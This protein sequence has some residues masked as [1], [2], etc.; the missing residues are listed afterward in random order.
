MHPP[1]LNRS[2]RSSR[3]AGEPSVP[4]SLKVTRWITNFWPAPL[5]IDR[6]E[7]LRVIVGAMF[8]ILLTAIVSRWW[9]GSATADPWML[10]S[11]GASAVLVFCMPSSPLAQPWPLLGGS[12]LSAVVG[13]LCSYAISDP[14]L[15]GA[16]AVGAAIALMVPLRCLHPPGGGVALYVVLTASDGVHLAVFPI[17]INVSILLITGVVYNGLTG[18]SYPHPQRVARSVATS[19]ASGA[20]TTSDIDAALAHYNE[21]LDVSRADLEG[22]L[23]LAGRAAFQRTLG[24]VLCTDVMSHPPIA[25][26]AGVSLKE[27]W[28]LMR[29]ERIKALP[30]VDGQGRVSGIVT[31]ADFMRSANLEVHEGLGH[32]LRAL[33]AGRSGQPSAVKDIMSHNVQVAR[34]VQHAMELVPLFS[35]GGHH[36]IP[37]VDVHD[38]LVGVIT[39]TDLIR[40]LASSIQGR[41]EAVES[42]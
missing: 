34:D 40:T 1:E 19:N 29:A 8:G 32:R 38:R 13:A 39:Q 31:V 28:T 17:F 27:A 37:I 10:A 41:N 42:N 3:P 11:F 35:S 20:F 33:V 5:G 21:V 26:E 23:H 30:V 14:M 36:H 18:R 4:F 25:V 2:S 16:V 7:W 24:E 9:M 22:F 6:R 12:T 15:A